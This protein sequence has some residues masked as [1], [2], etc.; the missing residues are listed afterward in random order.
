MFEDRAEMFFSVDDRMEKYYCI[1]VDCR[2]R[3]FDYRGCY[4]RQINPKWSLPGLQT[5][6]SVTGRRLRR[7][8][9]NTA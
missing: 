3:T 5:K 9:A 2:G 7:R 8:R 4:Y 1:E 6:A